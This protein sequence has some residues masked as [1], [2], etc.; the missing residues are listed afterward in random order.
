MIAETTAG[1]ALSSV[2]QWSR[3]HIRHIIHRAA[4][5]LVEPAGEGRGVSLIVG[6]DAA[7]AVTDGQAL[8]ELANGERL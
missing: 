8:E 3:L 6:V 7:D 2:D 1:D 4:A 5:D